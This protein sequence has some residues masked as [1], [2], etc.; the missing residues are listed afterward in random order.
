MTGL[1]PRGRGNLFEERPGEGRGRSIPAWAGEPRIRSTPPPSSEVYPRVGGGT[2]A[3]ADR[4]V[5]RPGLSPR[6]RGNPSSSPGVNVQIRSIPAWAG[7]PC[8]Q[9]HTKRARKVYPRVGGGTASAIASAGRH[10]GLSPRGRG[11]PVRRRRAGDADRSIPA[12]AGEPIG[13]P[14]VALIG[15]VYPRVGG[16]TLAPPLVSMAIL[17]LSPRGRGNRVLLS[18]VPTLIRSIPAWAGE[19]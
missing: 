7:E 17:G 5:D 15:G 18:A 4:R 19:P 10:E 3:F 11:N 14:I 9:R 1:S 2:A 12:W 6:G 13:H 16:G 8:W